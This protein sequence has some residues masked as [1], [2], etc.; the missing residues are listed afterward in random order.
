MSVAATPPLVL[1]LADVAEAPLALVGGKARGLGQLLAGGF[2]VP[3]G[4]VVTAPACQALLAAVGLA[5]A[6]EALARRLAAPALAD[7]ASWL[8]GCRSRLAAA[9]VPAEVAAALRAVAGPLLDGG[10][11]VVRS[12]GSLEDLAGARVAGPYE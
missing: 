5:D 4:V 11:L 8:A 10:L 7:E 3:E 1:P 2:P 12:S 9:G 6:R